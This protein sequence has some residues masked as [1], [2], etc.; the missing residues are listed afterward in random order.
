MENKI[1][2]QVKILPQ[3]LKLQVWDFIGYLKNKCNREDVQDYEKQLLD[4]FGSWEDDREPDE[5]IREIYEN[6]TISETRSAL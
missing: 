5:I 3:D 1:V 4:T 6:R 2:E